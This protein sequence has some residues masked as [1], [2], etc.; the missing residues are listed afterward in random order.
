MVVG[1]CIRQRHKNETEIESHQCDD[2][3]S[4]AAVRIVR[5]ATEEK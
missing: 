4:Q 1:Q 3:A 5:E 2:D